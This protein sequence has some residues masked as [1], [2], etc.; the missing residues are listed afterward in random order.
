MFLTGGDTPSVDSALSQHF[1][2]FAQAFWH[3]D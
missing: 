1:L 2:V 3:S